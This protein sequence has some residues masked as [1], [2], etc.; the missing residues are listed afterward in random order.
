MCRVRQDGERL[1]W[2]VAIPLSNE[3]PFLIDDVTPREKRVPHGED[4]EHRI[5]ARGTAE[6]TVS[7]RDF[8]GA[9]QR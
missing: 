4:A 8:E 2:K 5:G 6:L 1:E 3:L 9:T 7:D